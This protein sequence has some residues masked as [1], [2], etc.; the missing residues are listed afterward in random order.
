MDDNKVKVVKDW[1]APSR[2]KS[3]HSFLGLTNFYRR[4]ISNFMMIM[5]PLMELTQKNQPFEWREQQKIAFKTLKDQF[6]ST[7]VLQYPNTLLPPWIK[8]D[9]LSFAIGAALIIK[10][11]EGWCSAAYMA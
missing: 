9:A 2:V 6:T 5:K 8:T 11:E 3:M 4:F 1:K 7:S 10:M